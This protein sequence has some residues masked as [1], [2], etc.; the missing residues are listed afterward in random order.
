[1]AKP[2]NRG[3]QI[4]GDTMFVSTLN[5]T[6]FLLDGSGNILLAK[7]ADVP[8][9]AD[10]G[11]A[12]GALFIQTDGTVGSS[13]YQNEGSETSCDFNAVSSAGGAA[14]PTLDD[15]FAGDQTLDLGSGSTLTID[16]SAGNNDV[17]TLTNS[18]GGS[19]DVIQFSNVGTG[20][21]IMGTSST[22]SFSKTGVNVMKST[23]IAGTA[24]STSVALTAGDTVFS[25]GSVAITDADD[26]ATLS[27][28]NDT[29]TTAS[30]FVFA[31]SGAFSGSTTT[32]F[33]TLT[34]S[35]LTTGTG[36]Y[37][38]LAGLT[39]GKGLHEV[40]N[41]LTSGQMLHLASSAT[42]ITTSGRLFL[43]DHTGATG[44]TATLNEFKTA[45]NDESILL[46]LTA[47]SLTTGVVLD[48]GP[49]V[50]LTT[51]EAIRIAHTTSVIAD[52][53]SLVRLSSSSTDTGG[54]TNGTLL[55]VQTTAQV[56][57]SV[58]K[59][60]GAAMTTGI[61]LDLSTTTG[62]TSGSVIRASTSTAGAVATNGAFS[63]NAS[64]NFTS[65]AATLGAFHVAGAATAAGTIMSILG[66]AMTTGV[67]LYISDPGVVMT[68]GSLLRVA[69]ATTGAVATN[70]IVSIVSTGAY[71]STSRAGLLNVTSA[72]TAGVVAHIIDTALVDG[73]LLV[74]EAVEGTLTTGKY[75]EC[76]DG[77]AN[78]FSVAK[79]GATVIAGS[80]AG[81]AALTL[82]LGDLVIT[83]TDASTITSVNGTG[84]TLLITNGG[85]AG[86]DKASLEVVANGTSNADSAVIRVVQDSLTGASFCLNLKQDDLDVGFINF[87]GVASADAL[88]PIS[89]HGTAA[90]TTDF[91]RVAI[92]GTKAWIAVSTSDPSA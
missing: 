89:T 92:N 87:E 20:K 70:G 16:R 85:A 10:A 40:A 65:T 72:T 7:A 73:S 60:K 49:L 14:A 53:G 83:D 44:T 86:A 2:F 41:A 55:D 61:L 21:D 77:A 28:T 88:S 1:M 24:G 27:V 8:T 71:T 38:P 51:G 31:G 75:I 43:S 56:A 79:Y 58:I 47:E 9:D 29:A 67:G 18:G 32:S 54:S 22:W 50:A 68:S 37:F 78:D 80:A 62:M 6:A 69:S 46:A 52:G 11:Y 12:K 4:G 36:F 84:S 13:L 48:F 39:E 19:G 15:I 90:A 42:A 45:A 5:L 17:L 76:F 66:G 30:V 26:A 35:G 81:T 23:T 57:G 74:L 3:L 82:S 64:G 25:D 34:P 91:I 59:F 63:F 33:L